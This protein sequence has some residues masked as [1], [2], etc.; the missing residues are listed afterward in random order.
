MDF[1]KGLA[2]TVAAALAGPGA[3]L[4]VEAL[5]KVFGWTNATKDKVE[6][7]LNGPLSSEDIARIKLAE[8]ALKE[9]EKE[10]GFKF[11]ELKVKDRQ[12]EHEQT[13]ET[14]RSGDN[15]E[16]PYVR[17]TRPLMARQSWYVM[18]LYIIGM[19]GWKA[20]EPTTQ[21]ADWELALILGAPAL[22]YMGFR[23]IFDKFNFGGRVGGIFKKK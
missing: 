13:Q 3:A 11:E 20:F 10:Y 21:G 6:S 2:P 15:A 5:S 12:H 4:A 16:D 18:G 22:T 23:S 7:I 1:L 17:H 14:I 19:E 8:L 9:K